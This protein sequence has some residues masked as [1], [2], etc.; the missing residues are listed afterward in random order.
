MATY[1]IGDVQGCFYQLEA[2]LDKIKF[3]PDKDHLWFA[4]DLVNRGPNS[5]EVLRFVRSLGKCATAVLGNHD[6]HLLAVSYG[7]RD[8]SVNDNMHDV[9]I[10][11]DREILLDWLRRRPMLHFDKKLNCA[12]VHAGLMPSW[13]IKK[14]LQYAGEVE[15]VLRSDHPEEFFA[16]MYGNEPG[17]W[18]KRLKG[19]NRLR[20]ITNTLTRLRFCTPDERI[21]FRDKGKPGSQPNGHFP[22]FQIDGRKSRDT[23][24]ICGHWS[25]LGYYAE[26]GIIALDT[27]CQWGGELT[28]QKIS[29]KDKRYKVKCRDLEN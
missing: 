15:A 16:E 29:G 19:F 9:L 11:K 27:G 2:L 3:D 17:K 10:A 7:Y 6:L 28:A 1:A 22:W 26:D 14:A 24:V 12:L 23:T 13:S 8:L 4:G 21:N 20:F 18:S 25:S 5:L